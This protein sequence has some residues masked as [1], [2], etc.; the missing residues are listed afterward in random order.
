MMLACRALLC[1]ALASVPSG[2]FDEKAPDVQLVGGLFDK[3]VQSGSYS[4][5][6]RVLFWHRRERASTNPTDPWKWSENAYST[7][8]SIVAVCSRLAGDEVYVAGI[9][10]DERSVIER[11]KFPKKKGRWVY[12]MT[13]PAPPIGTPAGP[14]SASLGLHGAAITMSTP[15]ATWY[16]PEITVIMETGQYGF[17]RAINVDPEGRFLLFSRYPEGDVYSIDL[18]Q[19]P[20][21]PTLAFSSTTHPELAA[22]GSMTIKQ[23]ETLGRVCIVEPADESKA[24][25]LANPPPAMLLIDANNDAI[26]E[27]TQVIPLQDFLD[28]CAI[29]QNDHCVWS[30]P[31]VHG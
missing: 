23:H 25:L 21:L 18:S 2:V 12:S 10:P 26:F 16:A 9:L 5:K 17:I 24:T 19:N 31:W 27:S 4:A 15:P 7:R 20:P 29:D 28:S 6:T 30:R 14:W 22:L 13:S 11:W 1:L 3:L 8:Y